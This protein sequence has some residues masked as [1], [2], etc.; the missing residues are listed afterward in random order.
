M[1]KSPIQNIS[2]I[3]QDDL[4]LYH[5]TDSDDY[6]NISAPLE[7]YFS[8]NYE[9]RDDDLVRSSDVVK[10]QV[11]EWGD[12]DEQMSDQEILNSEFFIYTRVT[13][14]YSM[15]LNIKNFVS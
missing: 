9:Q 10:Y 5:K 12:E 14:Q 4:F 15:V 7:V 2:D 6:K 3:E 13:I 8:L 1:T 11:L